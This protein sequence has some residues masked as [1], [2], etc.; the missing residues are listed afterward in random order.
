M[1]TNRQLIPR[2]WDTP[3]PYKHTGLTIAFADEDNY[4]FEVKID[5]YSPNGRGVYEFPYLYEWLDL[6][7][8]AD[9]YEVRPIPPPFYKDK[10]YYREELE[11]ALMD[12]FAPMGSG[13]FPI[14]VCWGLNTTWL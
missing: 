11:A 6:E 7:N 5:L 4:L 3:A 10:S 1:K 13:I 2:E 12:H 8:G 14:K 9:R